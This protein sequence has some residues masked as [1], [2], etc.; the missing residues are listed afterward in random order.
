MLKETK[1][2]KL[3]NKYDIALDR[4]ARYCSDVRTMGKPREELSDELDTLFELVD[5]ETPVKLKTTM[6]E[7]NATDY[8]CPKCN[9]IVNHYDNYC[10]KCGQRLVGSY[11]YEI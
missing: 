7:H 11:K 2:L 10:S 9:N 8:R 3:N 6:N 5:K 4:V 1:T